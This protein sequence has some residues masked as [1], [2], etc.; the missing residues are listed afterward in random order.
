MEVFPIFRLRKTFRWLI[1]AES[2]F[3]CT[4]CFFSV[5]L[6]C[7]LC[8]TLTH[9]YLLSLTHPSRLNLTII[10]FTFFVSHSLLHRTFLPVKNALTLLFLIYRGFLLDGWIVLL[11]VYIRWLGLHIGLYALVPEK[12]E[13]DPREVWLRWRSSCRFGIVHS[14]A[15]EADRDHLRSVADHNFST[16]SRRRCQRVKISKQLFSKF[17]YPTLN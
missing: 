16:R 17:V 10:F 2:Y 15:R 7:H 13:K 8:W 5:I 3:S 14:D 12:Q 4:K 11:L 9:G 1:W 6:A